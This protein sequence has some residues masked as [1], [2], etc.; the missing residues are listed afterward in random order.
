VSRPAHKGLGVL[1]RPS[2]H[3]QVDQALNTL[4]I[5]KLTL[6]ISRWAPRL[7]SKALRGVELRLWH[8]ERERLGIFLRPGRE[9]G[10]LQDL[11]GHH[12]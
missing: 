5:L 7:T 12:P 3:L 1:K 6:L 8:P 10:P 11:W 9:K 2:T 4:I